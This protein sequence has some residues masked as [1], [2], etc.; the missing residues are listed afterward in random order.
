MIEIISQQMNNAEYM[1]G[2]TADE[3]SVEY[4][5][6]KAHI[7]KWQKSEDGETWEDFRTEYIVPIPTISADFVYDG[8]EKTPVITRLDE[9][10]VE[11]TGVVPKTNAGTYYITFS[12]IDSNYKWED[13]TTD[14]IEK[15][16]TIEKADNPMTVSPITII[17][18]NEYNKTYNKSFVVTGA[19]GDVSYD[20]IIKTYATIDSNYVDVSLNGNSVDIIIK[21]YDPTASRTIQ[22]SLTA[23]VAVTALGNENYKAITIPTDVII[24]YE[25]SIYY[26]FSCE[27]SD[28]PRSETQNYYIKPSKVSTRLYRGGNI[29]TSV[30]GDS[31]VFF[32]EVDKSGAKTRYTDT[33]AFEVLGT[34]TSLSNPTTPVANAFSSNGARGSGALPDYFTVYF[35]L[36]TSSGVPIYG[37]VEFYDYT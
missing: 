23:T 30:V 34:Y 7:L 31:N 11:V 33:S 26:G 10:Y 4:S 8:T 16:W 17:S 25:R 18:T 35:K 5:A 6:D 9:D 2:D 1:V 28:R 20:D 15:S 32:Y 24:N 19:I 14:D 12:L 22:G 13:G 27:W 3:L 37:Y 29:I 36:T 21:P